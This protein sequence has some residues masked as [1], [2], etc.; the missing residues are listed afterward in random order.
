[1]LIL[2]NPL[3]FP[4]GNMGVEGDETQL[5]TVLSFP[6]STRAVCPQ[7]DDYEKKT[8]SKRKKP[9]LAPNHMKKGPLASSFPS[10]LPL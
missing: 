3:P 4:R 8:S 7:G 1:M 10:W 6:D 2:P 9:A 5:E